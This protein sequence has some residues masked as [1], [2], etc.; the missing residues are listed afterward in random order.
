MSHVASLAA[1]PPGGAGWAPRRC[2]P[3]IGRDPRQPRWLSAIDKAA[4]SLV[5]GHGLAAPIAP[6][7]VPGGDLA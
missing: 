6:F 2:P 7:L 1:V 3:R 5:A 4:V